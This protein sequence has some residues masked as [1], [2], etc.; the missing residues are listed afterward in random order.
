MIKY[1][2]AHYVQEKRYVLLIEK[3]SFVWS[4][5]A[6]VFNKPF[7]A[8]G[9]NSRLWGNLWDWAYHKNVNKTKVLHK[10][11]ITKAEALKISPNFLKTEDKVQ[12]AAREDKSAS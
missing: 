1:N 6:R 4:T 5:L 3:E 12:E 11:K 10:V 7:R 9:Y 8:S 2:V